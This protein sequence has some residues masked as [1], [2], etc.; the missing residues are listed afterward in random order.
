MRLARRQDRKQAAILELKRL[1]QEGIA[2]GP[3]EPLDFDQIKREGRRRLNA[4]R[5]GVAVNRP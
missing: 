4:E 5:A 3:A 2:S 1:W